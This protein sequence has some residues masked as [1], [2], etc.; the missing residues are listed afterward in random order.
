VRVWHVLGGAVG[1]EP[2]TLATLHTRVVVVYSMRLSG[3]YLRSELHNTY[4]QRGPSY[5]LDNFVDRLSLKR[6]DWC[7]FVPIAKLV[8]PRTF[9]LRPVLLDC[10]LLERTVYT[11]LLAS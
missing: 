11:S 8:R 6:R 2:C 3:F 1:F 7:Q 10:T 4:P 5:S 9:V